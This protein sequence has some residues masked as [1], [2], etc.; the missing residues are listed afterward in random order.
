MGFD[1]AVATAIKTASHSLRHITCAD[2]K[3]MTVAADEGKITEY[4]VD[5]KL[6]FALDAG[7]AD[8]D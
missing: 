8:D 5:L 3:H 2:V 7:D 4:R 1:D 6:A